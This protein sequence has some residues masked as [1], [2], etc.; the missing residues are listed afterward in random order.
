MTKRRVSVLALVTPLLGGSLLGWSLGCFPRKDDIEGC[1]N[2]DDCGDPADHRYV[3]VCIVEDRDIEGV[4]VAD[5]RSDLN[6]NEMVYV[7]GEP[8]GPYATAWNALS[9]AARYSSD[10]SDPMFQGTKG[11]P[12]PCQGGL[13][14]NGNGVC[15]DG[16]GP[17]AVQS[18]SEYIGQDLRDQFCASYFCD[19]D[20]VCNRANPSQPLCTRCDPNAPYGEGGC[21]RLYINGAMSCAYQTQAQLDDACAAPDAATLNVTFGACMP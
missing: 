1:G 6:C 17:P 20:F 13:T 11:C 5:F 2:A 18:K 16:S 4:C 14:V 15:D 21:G 3:S 8:M 19:E 7:E 10:C 12:G 9:G